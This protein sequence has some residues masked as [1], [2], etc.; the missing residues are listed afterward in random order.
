V[1]KVAFDGVMENAY[2]KPV[3]PA[4]PYAGSFMAYENV[5]EIKDRNDYPSDDEI[6]AFRNNQRKANER[7]KAMTA[8]LDAAG[9]VKPTLENDQQL[10]LRS[11]YKVFIAAKKTPEEAR[12]LASSTLGVEWAD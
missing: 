10:Q 12:A 4:L 6:I 11:M 9:Y 1:K 5:T 3:T 7:Q 2:G 8:V